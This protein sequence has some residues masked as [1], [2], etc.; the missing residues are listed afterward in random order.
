MA[1]H[2]ISSESVSEGHPDK[3]ADQISD[4]VLDACLAVDPTSRVAVETAVK[5]NLVLVAG[6]LTTRARP[7]ISGIIAETIERIGYTDAAFEDSFACA[8][9]NL[10]ILT[11]LVRQSPDIAQGVDGEGLDEQ[12][13]G[14]QGMMYGYACNE[15]PELMPVS[16]AM[17]H[18][19][20][21]GTTQAR[22]TGLIR[23]LR[24]DSK[25][26][27]TIGYED[28]RPRAVSTVVISVQHDPDVDIENEL[29]AALMQHV[30]LPALPPDLDGDKVRFLVNPTGKFVRGG[31]FADAG[32]TGRKIIVDTYGGVG[33]HGGGAFSG[34]DPSK[35]DRSAAYAMRWVAKHVVASGAAARCEVQIA[36]AIGVAQPVSIMVE[37]FG[38]ENAD[39]NKIAKVISELFDLR[40]AAIV[41]DLDLRRPI[42]GKTAKYGHFGRQDPD[43]TWEQTPRATAMASALGLS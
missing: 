22:R 3:L 28:G 43:F 1:V 27:V 4:G 33:R 16:I 12:G 6:E 35:V 13:A 32:V 11:A 24:P 38:T 15:T 29:R 8:P 18:R 10:Q 26:M 17:A 20:T 21:L 5:S 23:G 37:T 9:G 39:P 31:A 7:D 19:L 25:S 14:D 2:F 40:P 41:R 36:Y 30:V 42:Y 34:K